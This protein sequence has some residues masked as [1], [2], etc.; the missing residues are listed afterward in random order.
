MRTEAELKEFLAETLLDATAGTG[1][2]SASVIRRPGADPQS[3][4]TPPSAEDPTFLVY[5]VTKTMT[6]ALLLKLAEEGNLTL[7]DSVSK[8]FPQVPQGDRISI[9]QLLNHSAGIPDYGG[10]SGY[11]DDVRRSPSSPWSFARFEAETFGKG[12]LFAPGTGWAY[13]NPAYMLLKGIIENVGGGSYK[14]VVNERLSK[15]MGLPSTAV[16]ESLREMRTLSAGLSSKISMDGSARDVREV[17]HPGWVSHG[18][19]AST[20]S[21]IA[22]FLDALFGGRYLSR[23]SIAEMTQLVPLGNDQR[24]DPTG[25]CASNPGYGLGLMGDRKSPWGLLLGHNGGGPAYAASAFHAPDLG[26]SVC[27]M[28]AIEDK[29][30]SEKVLAAILNYCQQHS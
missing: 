25:L 27:V 11:H 17:Y 6:A 1:T 12:L 15:P 19:V 21:D 5:S 4:W 29:F 13:S 8:W 24:I 9:R 3:F 10:L 16:V 14:Y 7:D 2:A 22:R 26:V 18:V 30:D 20:T 28:G 23:D